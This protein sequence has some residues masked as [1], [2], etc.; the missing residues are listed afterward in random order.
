LQHQVGYESVITRLS[1]NNGVA[2]SPDT[3]RR[4]IETEIAANNCN[5]FV[6]QM[7][8]GDMT[9]KES[10]RSVELFAKEIMPAF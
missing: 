5:Y 6:P 3:V 4:Y 7:V 8:F 1:L 2:G 9:L 10:L